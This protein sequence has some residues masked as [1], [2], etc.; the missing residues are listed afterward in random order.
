[1]TNSAYRTRC[2][3]CGTVVYDGQWIPP[4]DRFTIEQ[5]HRDTC[6]ADIV[7]IANAARNPLARLERSHLKL[8]EQDQPLR[9][10]RTNLAM[11]RQS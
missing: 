8:R 5:D 6:P 7:P 2:R 11:V 9:P 3:R 10:Y 1:M 4:A